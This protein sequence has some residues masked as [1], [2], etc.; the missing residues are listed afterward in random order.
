ML[1]EYL[2]HYVRLDPMG[3]A[4]ANI[5]QTRKDVISLLIAFSIVFIC[6]S[7]LVSLFISHRIAGPLYKLQ[8]HFSEL[9]KGNFD[10]ELHFRKKDYFTELA[11]DYNDMVFSLKKL[12]HRE[13]PQKDKESLSSSM[14]QIQEAMPHVTPA[15]R[16]YLE[17]ALA[18]LKEIGK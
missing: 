18:T 6:L 13:L 2:A 15:G 17:T 4:L 11:N 14:N 3:P 5:E 9:G 10:Q 7:F 16:T 1:F 8:K 12:L